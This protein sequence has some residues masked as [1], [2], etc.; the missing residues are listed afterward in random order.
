MLGNQEIEHGITKK[1]QALVI[2]P[3]DAAVGK[4]GFEQTHIARLV[5]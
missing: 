3:R 1:L 4:G 2:R 5:G